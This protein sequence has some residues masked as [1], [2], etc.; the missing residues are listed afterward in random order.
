MNLWN[1]KSSKSQSVSS[2]ST[3]ILRTINIW[4]WRQWTEKNPGVD[5][6]SKEFRCKFKYH[7]IKSY[8]SSPVNTQ[9][10][11]SE[12]GTY[13]PW[14]NT[15]HCMRLFLTAERNNSFLEN[16]VDS[17][18]NPRISSTCT[19][20]LSKRTFPRKT[21]QLSWLLQYVCWIMLCLQV[22]GGLHGNRHP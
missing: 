12:T 6:Y 2:V 15:I 3:V 5:E 19:G 20:K 16:Y 10:A 4:K 18:C 7:D 17:F 9:C 14:F 21:H 8:K 13:S 11:N 1:S 22:A